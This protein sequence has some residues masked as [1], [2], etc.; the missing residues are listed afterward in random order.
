MGLAAAARAAKVPPVAGAMSA[1][2]KVG[3]G[4]YL[5]GLPAGAK[6]PAVAAPFVTADFKGPIPTN[7][8]CSSLYW[9]KFSHPHYAHPLAMKAV[10]AGLRVYYPG[11]TVAGTKDAIFGFMPDGK[12]D[13]GDLTIGHSAVAEF[14]EKRVAAASDWFVDVRWQAGPAPG[15]GAAGAGGPP[16]AMTL[17]YG[18]GSPF[19]YAAYEGGGARVTFAEVP[20]VWSGDEKSTVIGLTV[21]GKHYGLFARDGTSWT[22]LGTRELTAALA[23]EPAQAGRV[24]ATARRLAVAALPEATREALDLFAGR[25]ALPVTA[26][27][28]GWAYDP[29]AAVVKTTFAFETAGGDAAHPAG[30]P[31]AALYPHQA[32]QTDAKLT[33]YGYP[34]VRGPMKLAAADAAGSPLVTGVAFPGVLPALPRVP[35][36]A[37]P[38]RLAEYLRKEVAASDDQAVRDTYAEGKLL[39]KWASLIPIAE[40]YGMDAEADA[41]T[42]RVKARLEDWFTATEPAGRPNA[43]SK[44]KSLTDPKNRRRLFAYDKTWTTL[45]GYPA[46]YGSDVELN[47]HHFHYGYFI[48]A[49][50]EVARRDPAWATDDRWGGMVKL[51]IRDV[52]SPDRA[53]PLFP[54]LRNFDPYAGHSWASG[55]ARFGDGNNHES[56]SEAMNAW[57][58]LLLWGQFTGDPKLRDLGAWLYTTEMTAIED[59]WFGVHDDTFAAGGASAGGGAFPKGY[60]PSVVTMIW[61]GKG[62]N[63][64]WFSGEPEAVHGINFLPVTGGSTYLGRYPAYVD[65]NW[66]ALLAERKGGPLRH[67]EDVLLMYRALSDPTDALARFDAATAA[68]GGAPKTGGATPG[69]KPEEGNSLANAYHWIATLNALGQVDRSVTADH[70]LAVTFVKD[71]KRTH[72]VYRGKAGGK[73]DPAATGGGNSVKFSDGV[74]VEATA[75]GLTVK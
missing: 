43:E 33:P 74:T 10:P 45:I 28:V 30:R 15:G 61:G 58:G 25:A 52:A 29:A 17:S 68:G 51:L 31:P 49:A 4:S 24:V 47:D 64:I 72:V 18:H 44:P 23:P 2:V 73:A 56:S 63:G 69:L 13:R 14:P 27:R 34:S 48:R 20:K 39:G 22:G 40:Q 60:T 38:A 9:E 57:Y 12:D 50:A 71:G 65:K 11:P 66:R 35:G 32:R 46:G 5:S 19:V 41:L 54:F 6:G 3:A 53:D 70:P 62:A 16:A 7:D 37:D 26:T 67:W 36:G 59:Y 75:E 55:H 8:W 42:K 1:V 21:G